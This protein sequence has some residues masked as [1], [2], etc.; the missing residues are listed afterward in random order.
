MKKIPLSEKTGQK[1][2]PVKRKKIILDG[3]WKCPKVHPDFLDKNIKTTKFVDLNATELYKCRVNLDRA[4]DQGIPNLHNRHFNSITPSKGDFGEPPDKLFSKFG[5]K[6]AIRRRKENLNYT[7][8]QINIDTENYNNRRK[9]YEQSMPPIWKSSSTSG[10]E[11]SKYKL[12]QRR[13]I[14]K[15]FQHE[16][17]NIILKN[18]LKG[19]KS[20]SMS[21]KL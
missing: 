7:Q 4:F 15:T 2:R 3:K 14:R 16:K 17:Y 6:K 5:F 9:R 12:D 11:F 21:L 8:D 1:K 19:T 10:E 13:L 18:L 20:G